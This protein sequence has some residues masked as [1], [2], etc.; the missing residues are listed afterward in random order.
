MLVM[1]S[2]CSEQNSSSRRPLSLQ[3]PTPCLPRTPVHT[4]QSRPTL[5]LKSPSMRTLSSDLTC[6]RRLRRSLKA[7]WFLGDSSPPLIL[8]HLSV[9]CVQ[10]NDDDDNCRKPPSLQRRPEGLEHRR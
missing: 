6:R 7:Y 4:L 8:F 2:S 9:K 3:F 10:Q 5:A 1:V